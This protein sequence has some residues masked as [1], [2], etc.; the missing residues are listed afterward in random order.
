[1]FIFVKFGLLTL[2]FYAVLTLALEAGIWA[3]TNF[4]GLMFFVDEKRPALSLAILP[5]I[6]FGSLW[7]LAFS[8]AWFIV[9]RD[10]RSVFLALP[11]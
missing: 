8:A 11:R 5:G 9:Y 7:L 4:K 10:F 2:A 1:M 6:V 3:L